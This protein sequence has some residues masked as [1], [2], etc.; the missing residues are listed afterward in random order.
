MSSRF[1]VG[2]SFAWKRNE[3]K[4]RSVTVE[5]WLLLSS[6]MLGSS[7]W[8]DISF[9]ISSQLITFRISERYACWREQMQN[10]GFPS[11]Y[12]HVCIHQGMKNA[13]KIPHNISA[14]HWRPLRPSSKN[15][16]DAKR[17]SL[18]FQTQN[19]SRNRRSVANAISRLR[20]IFSCCTSRVCSLVQYTLFDQDKCP[21]WICT[22]TF[23]LHLLYTCE[24]YWNILHLNSY[25]SF[26]NVVQYLL[27]QN[28]FN[29]IFQKYVCAFCRM[30]GLFQVCP[31]WKLALRPAKR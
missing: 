9:L 30:K 29:T 31:G 14:S 22:G 6:I 13:G 17:T 16:S 1:R 20:G 19:I 11:K 27:S 18:S 3:N 8:C 15:F 4:H 24:I 26:S 7:V 23:V 10:K 5:P 25:K 21:P 12:C 2:E 28:H